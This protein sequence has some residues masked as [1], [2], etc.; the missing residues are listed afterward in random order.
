M[1]I[2]LSQSYENSWN[3]QNFSPFFFDNISLL[4]HHEFKKMTY[5]K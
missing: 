1:I 4:Q 5:D 2:F 3:A